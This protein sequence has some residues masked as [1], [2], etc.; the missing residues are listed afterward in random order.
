MDPTVYVDWNALAARALLRAAPVLLRPELTERAV[1]LLDDW[2]TS[3]PPS[4]V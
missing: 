1:E 2:P 4:E 3:R